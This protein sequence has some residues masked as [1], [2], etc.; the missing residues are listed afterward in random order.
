[1]GSTGKDGVRVASWPRSQA[2]SGVATAMHRPPP[3]FCPENALSCRLHWPRGPGSTMAPVG[4]PRTDGGD[5]H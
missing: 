1:M 5:H 3:Y 2:Q 4:W